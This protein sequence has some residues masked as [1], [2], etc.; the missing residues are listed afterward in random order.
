MGLMSD[1]IQGL[2]TIGRQIPMHLRI[3]LGFLLVFFIVVLAFAFTHTAAPSEMSYRFA[4]D[5]AGRVRT[6]TNAEGRETE[7]AYDQDGRVLSIHYPE[8]T[9]TLKYDANGQLISAADP[10]GRSEFN[11]DPFGR[12]I[13]ATYQHGPRRTVEYEYDPWGRLSILKVLCGGQLEQRLSYEYDLTGMLMAIRDGAQRIEYTRRPDRGETVRRLPNGITSTFTYSLRGQPLSIV[14]CDATGQLLAEYGYEYGPRGSIHSVT[15]RSPRGEK[16]YRYQWDGR[17]YL[18]SLTSPDNHDVQYDYDGLGN[19]IARRE[20]GVDTSY[21]YDPYGRLIGAGT[22]NYQYDRAGYLT[23][24]VEAEKSRRFT[25][26]SEGRLLGANLPGRTVHFAYDGLGEMVSRSAGRESRHYLPNP[27]G[28]P[29]A[30]LAELDG[31]GNLQV[32]YVYGDGLLSA[33]DNSGTTHYFLEDGFGSIRQVADTAGRVVGGC[34]YS[35]FGEIT[36][37]WGEQAHGFRRAGERRDTDLGYSFI[38]TRVYHPGLGRNLAPDMSGAYLLRPDSF[39]AYAHSCTSRAAFSAPRCNQ[40][41]KRDEVNTWAMPPDQFW[42]VNPSPA[43]SLAAVRPPDPR[44]R[45]PF[46]FSWESPGADFYLF[47]PP[48]PSLM[49]QPNDGAVAPNALAA[50]VSLASLVMQSAA[51]ETVT[52]NWDETSQR[53]KVN[54]ALQDYANTIAAAR[55]ARGE[56]PYTAVPVE[57]SVNPFTGRVD[58]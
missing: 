54:N 5:D 6:C 58:V 8:R 44:D 51:D 3:F 14:H 49:R 53:L 50:L 21:N 35:P 40:T 37:S 2:T 45:F 57:V 28:P 24:A 42:W 36:D 39:N 9:V 43:P 10:R 32:L 38:G 12:V 15:E 23:A 26:D 25:W 48:S 46:A 31:A 33:R 18:T 55:L 34:D 29:G 56:D 11:Y 47:G 41:H 1:V 20:G 27:L 30:T 4:Y 19:R 17:V 7:Y 22:D 52:S 16:T 13:S